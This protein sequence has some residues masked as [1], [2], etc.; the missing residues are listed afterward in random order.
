MLIDATSRWANQGVS[1]QETS[2]SVVGPSG[3]LSVYDVSQ[4]NDGYGIPNHIQW[5][6][7][8]LQS[9]VE[10]TV[11]FQN[12]WLDGVWDDFTYTFRLI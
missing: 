7:Q 9:G 6:V 12:V 4:N 10:Y 2:I 1:F 11:T 5:R 8:G 3:P